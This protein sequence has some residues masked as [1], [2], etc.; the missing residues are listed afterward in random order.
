MRWI[1]KLLLRIRSLFHRDDVDR[2][3]EQELSFHMEQQIATHIAAGMLPEEAR[4]AAMREFGGV[5]QIREQCRDTRKVNWVQDFL[6]DIRYGS[7][8]LRKSPGFTAVA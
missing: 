5:E 2:E 8:M 7:R 4:Y 3:M 1:H 6:Q